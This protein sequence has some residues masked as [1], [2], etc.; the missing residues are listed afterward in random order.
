M[1]STTRSRPEWNEEASR[2]W[3]YVHQQ[4]VHTRTQHLQTS[5]LMSVYTKKQLNQLI[6]VEA[7]NIR[8][9]IQHSPL[10]HTTASRNDLQ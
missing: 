1:N 4:P 10:V 9:K 5:R 3:R 7:M 8:R 2:D 6:E